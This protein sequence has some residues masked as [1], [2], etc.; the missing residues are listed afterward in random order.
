MSF[1]TISL[2]ADGSPC[3]FITL[4]I[5]A[6]AEDLRHEPSP[7]E[8]Q[9][10]LHK[11]MLGGISG[12][13]TQGSRVLDALF[14]NATRRLAHDRSMH[15][16]EKL[17]EIR[18]EV[19]LYPHIK[20][21]IM[22]QHEGQK[23]F[24]VDEEQKGRYQRTVDAWIPPPSPVLYNRRYIF[25]SNH[26]SKNKDSTV[27]PEGRHKHTMESN[28]FGIWLGDGSIDIANQLGFRPGIH[29]NV[30]SLMPL[31]GVLP[32]TARRPPDNT[33]TDI[34]LFDL[35]NRIH[36][37]FGRETCVTVV[38][39]GCRLFKWE[40]YDPGAQQRHAELRR[41]HDKLNKWVRPLLPAP[42]VDAAHTFVDS[43][44]SDAVLSPAA[45]T[46]AVPEIFEY[47]ILQDGTPCNVVYWDRNG[48]MKYH[49]PG[50]P[51]GELDLTRACESDVKYTVG[52]MDYGVGDT[53]TL[54]NGLNFTIFYILEGGTWFFVH[55]AVDEGQ[56]LYFT[57][58]M[59]NSKFTEWMI[60]DIAD[61]LPDKAYKYLSVHNVDEFVSSAHE[62]PIPTPQIQFP[63]FRPPYEYDGAHALV[64][65]ALHKKQRFG[66]KRSRGRVT[67]KQH[68]RRPITRKQPKRSKSKK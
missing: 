35:V 33:A 19:L 2:D 67:K 26:W 46:S 13:V 3:K 42:L 37:L 52:G 60:G 12:N 58:V 45:E 28:E 65:T 20:E 39:M 32:T 36:I 14:F 23:K 59:V 66:G 68:K 61:F 38:D 11:L 51:D 62:R 47:L 31:L 5:I 7:H 64:V 15:H 34:T 54:P 43:V 50:T 44:W 56:T 21:E 40:A 24:V 55:V 10:K 41:T 6:H 22:K 49:K 29:P 18:K 57:P 1:K 9:N 53:I 27:N 30:V 48:A 25:N 16:V 17:H 63:P 8:F 4:F